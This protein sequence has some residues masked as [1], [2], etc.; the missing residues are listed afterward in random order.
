VDSGFK[1]TI[2]SVYSEGSGERKDRVAMAAAPY[3]HRKAG[4]IG[5][6]KEEQ[7]EAAKEAEKGRFGPASM[8]KI[9][10]FSR[11]GE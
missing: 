3:C 6:K 7:A 2:F 9:L 5:G 11:T 4:R 10:N 1:N 8:P